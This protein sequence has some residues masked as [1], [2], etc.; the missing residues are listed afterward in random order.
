[1]K[2]ILTGTLGAG[3]GLATEFFESQGLRKYSTGDIARGILAGRGESIER[4]NL[5]QLGYDFRCELILG[6]LD[7]LNREGRKNDFVIDCARYPLQIEMVRNVYPESRLIAVDADEYLRCQRLINRGRAGD[8]KNKEEFEVQN[9]MDLC[10][11]LNQRGQDVRGC[12]KL[13]EKVICNDRTPEEF[14][15]ELSG[16]LESVRC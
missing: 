10:G 16:W 5:Q 9:E 8:P 15:Q 3:K 11:Y 1:M 14:I 7:R 4:A 6:V 13:V 2:I 12:L